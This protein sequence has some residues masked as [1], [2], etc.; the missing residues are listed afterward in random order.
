MKPKKTLLAVAAVTLLAVTM[1]VPATTASAATSSETTV[2]GIGTIHAKLVPISQVQASASKNVVTPDSGVGEDGQV[3]MQIEG[4][5]WHMDFWTLTG[6]PMA[7]GE[8][9]FSTY[10]FPGNKIAFHG[11]D[12]CNETG[13]PAIYI[14]TVDNVTVNGNANACSTVLGM[15]GKPCVYVW[16]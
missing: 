2:V 7:P 1:L 8:C 4:S 9:T 12:L 10:W 3:Y 14:S 13:S 6:S 5:G 16:Q 15:S 11:P